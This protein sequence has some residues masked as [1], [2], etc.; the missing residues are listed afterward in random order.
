MTAYLSEQ[1]ERLKEGVFSSDILV[2]LCL[3]YA[4]DGESLFVS[5]EELEN[6]GQTKYLIELD[7]S[8]EE[9]IE[10]KLALDYNVDADDE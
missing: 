6:A 3:K 8:S 5:R 2:A 10:I 1:H 9:E 7:D 4:G